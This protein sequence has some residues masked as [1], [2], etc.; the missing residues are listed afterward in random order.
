VGASAWPARTLPPFRTA[1]KKTGQ[2]TK[3]AL[4]VVDICRVG[5]A[6][7]LSEAKARQALKVLR[8]EQIEALRDRM[9][10]GGL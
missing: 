5:A 8:P 1:Y 4:H 2:L 3:N 10:W 6:Y 7:N 9:G